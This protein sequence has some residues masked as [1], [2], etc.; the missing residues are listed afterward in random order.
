MFAPTNSPTVPVVPK[1][2]MLSLLIWI[3]RPFDR[4]E[5]AEHAEHNH[6]KTKMLV[7]DS[8]QFMRILCIYIS[9]IDCVTNIIQP[10]VARLGFEAFED[11]SL[12]LFRGEADK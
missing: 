3:K 7:F 4:D 9:M 2:A 6:P 12:S 11:V 1:V 8:D 5:R 10:V